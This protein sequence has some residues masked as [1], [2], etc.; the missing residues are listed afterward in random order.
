MPV[1]SMMSAPL[2][3]R[4]IEISRLQ[5]PLVTCLDRRPF[6]VDD[7]IPGGVAIL[8]LDH[9]MLSEHALER[10]TEAQEWANGLIADLD[11]ET[12]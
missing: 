2:P 7:R 4:R 3:S 6:L 12:R 9:E 8:A 11:D 1:E 5:P 10:E